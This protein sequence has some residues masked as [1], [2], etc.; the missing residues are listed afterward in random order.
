MVFYSEFKRWLYFRIKNY[1]QISL[2][3]EDLILYNGATG[4]NRY[5]LYTLL[6]SLQFT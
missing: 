1:Q 3:Y 6:H 2:F 4:K 5:F